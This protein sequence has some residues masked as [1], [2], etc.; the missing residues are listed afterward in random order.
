MLN[1]FTRSTSA[2]P[3][4]PRIQASNF[5]P[6]NRII[7][8][9]AS[10]IHPAEPFVQRPLKGVTKGESDKDRNHRSCPFTHAF[11]KSAYHAEQ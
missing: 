5:A 11:Y 6:I 9:I 7:K 2:V 10:A 4:F 1:A 8:L 3:T